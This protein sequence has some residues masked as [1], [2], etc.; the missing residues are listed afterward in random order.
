MTVAYRCHR[1]A[2]PTA[3]DGDAVLAWGVPRAARPAVAAHPRPVGGARQ[4]GDAAAD[5]GAAGDPEVVRRSSTP[6]RRR[7]RARLR[8]SATCC[9]VWQ[10]LGYPRR[11]RNLHAAADGGG[12]PHGGRVPDDARRL[13]ALAGD[14]PV[15]GAGGAGVRLRA[16][17]RRRRH[18][19]RP[20]AGPRAGRA[21]DAAARS[22]RSADELVPR[23]RR[24]GVEPGADGP[25]RHAVPAAHRGATSARC[26]ALR[27]A[28]R[29]PEPDPAVGSAGVSVRQA[30]YE[31][32][33]RQASGRLLAALRDG[34]ADA[35]GGRGGDALDR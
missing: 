26:A 23:R 24:L 6:S 25:R 13:L 9:G 32:S 11:A 2:A 14:R 16:R 29:R 12:R 1:V 3:L 8:R 5:P 15:H 21:A 35:A 7:R 19:H 27:V 33:D 30:P 17:R 34:G 31:G 22:R 28:R 10:G 20:G 18:E 4:R